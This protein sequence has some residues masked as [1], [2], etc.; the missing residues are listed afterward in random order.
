ML[1]LQTP[2]GHAWGHNIDQRVAIYPHRRRNK[3]W[4]ILVCFF[5]HFL[6]VTVVNAWRLY[7]MSGLEKLNLIFFKASELWTQQSSGWRCF[8]T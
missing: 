4:Y 5:F 2:L 7:L 3:R 8:K 1:F 6:D